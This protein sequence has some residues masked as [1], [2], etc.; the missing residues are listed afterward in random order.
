MKNSILSFIVLFFSISLVSAESEGLAVLKG[1]EKATEI[2]TD[3][4][5]IVVITQQKAEQGTK[6]I[7]MIYYR[8]DRD[9]SFLIV[10]NAPEYEKG[11]GYLRVGENF[12]M[13]RK[14]TRT[15]QHVSRD[16]SIGGSDANGDDFEQWKLTERYA[17]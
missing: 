8:R 3:A 2:K 10:M 4:K 1:I 9:N 16:E 6:V 7:Q 13:Y 11:N 17:P 14:N 12:W 5:G 15:F